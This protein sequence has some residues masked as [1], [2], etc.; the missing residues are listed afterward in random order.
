MELVHDV[1]LA[2]DGGVL[3]L[4]H[5][6]GELVD[7]CGEGVVQDQCLYKEDCD[8]ENGEDHCVE[9]VHGV[10]DDHVDLVIYDHDEV[11]GVV[12]EDDELESDETCGPYYWWI[13]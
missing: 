3:E 8:H 9:V 4:V 6:D 10:H 13:F 2:A 12:P 1:E 5:D 7:G 11:S